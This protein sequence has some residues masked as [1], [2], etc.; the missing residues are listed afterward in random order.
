MKLGLQ[1]ATTLEK[2]FAQLSFSLCSSSF[3]KRG[4]RLSIFQRPRYSASKLMDWWF[5]GLSS[6]I[7]LKINHS[8]LLSVPGFHS[9]HPIKVFKP[10]IIMWAHIIPSLSCLLC[11]TLLCSLPKT[12]WK[13]AYSSCGGIWMSPR[14]FTFAFSAKCKSVYSKFFLFSIPLLDEK[15]E[16]KTVTSVC[17]SFKNPQ[18]NGRTAW[19]WKYRLINLNFR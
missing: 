14:I 8:I 19:L 13:F 10:K 2:E 1:W 5:T 3:T 6:F 17:G 9:R 12:R 11:L 15:L 4:R 7:S 18:H 16:M